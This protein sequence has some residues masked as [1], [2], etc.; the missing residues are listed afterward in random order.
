MAT[1]RARTGAAGTPP[2]T[3]TGGSPVRRARTVRAWSP[4]RSPTASTTRTASHGA[5]ERSSSRT[6]SG[7]G[8][9]GPVWR[10][11]ASTRSRGRTRT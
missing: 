7:P 6:I 3:P 11:G 8:T 4:G 9:S 5:T 1:A 2:L 10:P